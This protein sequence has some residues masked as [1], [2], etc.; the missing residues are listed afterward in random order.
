M[1]ISK[2]CTFV[3]NNYIISENLRNVEL[4]GYMDIVIDDINDR[5]QA[6]FP[7]FSEWNDYVTTYNVAHKDVPDFTPLSIDT[8]SAIPARYLRSVVALGAAL[9]FFTN[10]EEG[11]QV[12]TKYYIQYE[13]NMFNMIRDYQELVPIEFRNETGG[14]ITTTYN[15]AENPE[16]CVEGIV[17][18]ND[19]YLNIF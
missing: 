9:N 15:A 13:R 5:L 19:N 8:Y 12:S 17:M 6:S 18:N 14:Y 11:E 2:L 10:D 4:M 16:A 3:N 1:N 7:T